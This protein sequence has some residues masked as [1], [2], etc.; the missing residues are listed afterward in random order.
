[1][2]PVRAYGLWM[3]SLPG[4]SLTQTSLAMGKSFNPGLLGLSFLRTDLDSEDAKKELS[5]SA[6]SALS[7]Y[8]GLPSSNGPTL[9]LV[10]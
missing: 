5:N 6:F 2:H 10:F 1:M 9:S 7:V 8:Q 3:F 4:R